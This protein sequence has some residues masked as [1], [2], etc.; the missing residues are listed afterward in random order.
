MQEDQRKFVDKHFFFVTMQRVGDQ[1]NQLNHNQN[2][3]DYTF[4]IQMGL[5][6]I[7]VQPSIEYLDQ[8]QLL[9]NN[10][11]NAADMQHIAHKLQMMPPISIISSLDQTQIIEIGK[12]LEKLNKNKEQIITFTQD[13]R[14]RKEIHLINLRNIEWNSERFPKFVADFILQQKAINNVNKTS[15]NAL[16][17]LRYLGSY[18]VK[19]AQIYSYVPSSFRRTVFEDLSLQAE[20]IKNTK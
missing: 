5:E 8:L 15:D 7:D 3:T 14:K 1:M 4:N 2:L 10:K 19:Y 11:D 13:N 20:S 12:V 9:I 17:N 16:R 6:Y 18:L